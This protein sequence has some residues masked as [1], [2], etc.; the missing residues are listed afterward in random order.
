MG[1]NSKGIRCGQ[2]DIGIMYRHEGMSA[3]WKKFAN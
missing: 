2:G 3:Y 1:A